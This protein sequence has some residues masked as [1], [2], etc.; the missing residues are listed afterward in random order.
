MFFKKWKSGTPSA[1]EWRGRWRAVETEREVSHEEWH[2]TY[3]SLRQWLG[4]TLRVGSN[5]LDDVFLR[6]VWYKEHRSH[7]VEL[8]RPSVLTLEF[9]YDLQHWI[10]ES[11]PTWRIIVPLFLGEDKVITVYRDVI[12]GAP[13]YERD[14]LGALERARK[15]IAELPLFAHARVQRTDNHATQSPMD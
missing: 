12:R 7:V 14:W 1:S 11:H 6:E 3:D 2:E 4:R 9:L 13:D 10:R 8:V 5:N 15:Q